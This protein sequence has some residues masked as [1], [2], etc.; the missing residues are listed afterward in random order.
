MSKKELGENNSVS[1]WDYSFKIKKIIRETNDPEERLSRL[2]NQKSFLKG[3]WDVFDSQEY[4]KI[5]DMIDAEIERASIEKDLNP[6]RNWSKKR[7]KTKGE[8]AKQRERIKKAI[9]DY[10][11]ENYGGEGDCDTDMAREIIE[12]LNSQYAFT[13]FWKDPERSI[14]GIINDY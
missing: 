10:Y 1:V 14:K 5:F 2:V 8:R 4:A 9:K 13:D 11:K 12:A 3:N 7:G 6:K